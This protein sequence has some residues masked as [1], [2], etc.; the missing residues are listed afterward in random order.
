MSR[1]SSTTTR[2]PPL[3]WTMDLGLVAVLLDGEDDVDVET[4]LTRIFSRARRFRR[5]P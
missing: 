2:P 5:R 1:L 3:P 4:S